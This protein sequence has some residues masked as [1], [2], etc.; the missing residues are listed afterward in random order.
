VLV[1]DDHRLFRTRLSELLSDEGDLTVVGECEDG[2]QVVK[3]VERL[4]PDV[5]LMALSMPVMNG[6]AAT[7][8]PRDVRS[9][10]RVVVLAG[11]GAGVRPV[12]AAA[13]PRW[14]SAADAVPTASDA[15][16]RDCSPPGPGASGPDSPGRPGAHV[17]PFALRAEQ[18]QHLGGLGARPERV[19]HVG[20]E[21]RRLAGLQ[22]DVVLAQQQP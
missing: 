14:S 20:V 6:L 10:P 12:V 7:G 16:R 15:N 1:V 18:A 13:S 21:L 2:A 8:A 17:H 9:E 4:R 3:A 22:R 5:V 11:E 19:R